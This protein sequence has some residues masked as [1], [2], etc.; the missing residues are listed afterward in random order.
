MTTCTTCG[1]QEITPV[2]AAARG[3]GVVK[4]ALKCSV[5]IHRFPAWMRKSF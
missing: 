5:C 3:W 2:H 4:R 1:T